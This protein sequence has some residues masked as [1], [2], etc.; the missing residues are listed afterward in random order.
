MRSIDRYPHNSLTFDRE[1]W[2]YLSIKKEPQTPIRMLAALLIFY[3]Q[4][5]WAEQSILQDTTS[6]NRENKSQDIKEMYL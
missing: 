1:L 5:W 4:V 6:Q 3:A 2:G